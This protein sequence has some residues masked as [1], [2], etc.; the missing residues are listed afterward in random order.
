MLVKCAI[1]H[2]FSFSL[3]D[4]GTWISPSA[5]RVGL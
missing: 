2:D 1:D 4:G 3:L 5:Q